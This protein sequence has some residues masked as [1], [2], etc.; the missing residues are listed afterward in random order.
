MGHSSINISMTCLGEVDIPEFIQ[1][2][3]SVV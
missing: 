1:D 2:D 3:M